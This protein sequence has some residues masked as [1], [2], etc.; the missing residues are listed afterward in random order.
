MA[1][2]SWKQTQMAFGKHLALVLAN[3][4]CSIDGGA[5]PL[6]STDLTVVHGNDEVSLAPG[7]N[8]N[9]RVRWTPVLLSSKSPLQNR[10]QRP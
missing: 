9:I 8:L 2:L 1:G 3:S 7:G 5:H 4:R 6:S 10:R